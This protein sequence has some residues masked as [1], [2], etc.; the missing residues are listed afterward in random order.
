MERKICTLTVLPFSSSSSFLT[1][2]DGLCI[3]FTLLNIGLILF[4]EKTAHCLK[5]DMDLLLSNAW[6]PDVKTLGSERSFFFNFF[7]IF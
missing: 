5:G 6:G 4:N 3:Q 7:F 1:T 2:A